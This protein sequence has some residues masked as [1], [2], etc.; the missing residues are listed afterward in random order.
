M[1]TGISLSKLPFTIFGDRS[2]ISPDKHYASTKATS[3][4]P[5]DACGG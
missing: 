4:L 2:D 3:S 1:H 5:P